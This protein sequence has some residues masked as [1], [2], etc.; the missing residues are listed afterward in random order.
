MFNEGLMM[1]ILFHG[2]DEATAV[3]IL[4]EGFQPATHFA[5]HLEDAL[6]YGGAYVF[7][8]WFE[9]GEGPTGYGWQTVH[10]EAVP[11]TKIIWLQRFES[12]ALFENARLMDSR[13]EGTCSSCHNAG[14]Y[15]H[16]RFIKDRR[17]KLCLPCE[18]CHGYGDVK[19][20]AAIRGN[21]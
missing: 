2:T 4:H 10:P 1:R 14:E 6:C 9:N 17:W 12:E 13:H 20:A 16:S 3:T 21:A 7:A 18:E 5:T 15:Q 19:T 11:N 8:V